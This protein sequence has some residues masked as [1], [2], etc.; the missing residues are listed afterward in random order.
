MQDLTAQKVNGI[1]ILPVDSSALVPAI[2][3]AVDAGIPVATT[4]L[5]APTSK[6]A[7]STSAETPPLQQGQMQA[8]KVAAYLKSKA[9]PAPSTTSSRPV[10]RP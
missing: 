3:A 5:D 6:R 2:N 7:S 10:C 1:V 9:P 4:E 8:D